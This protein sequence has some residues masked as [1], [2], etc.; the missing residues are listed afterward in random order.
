M[1]ITSPKFMLRNKIPV[2]IFNGKLEIDPAEI[3]ALKTT[4][5]E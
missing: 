5:D 2:G 4:E 3:F 1:T